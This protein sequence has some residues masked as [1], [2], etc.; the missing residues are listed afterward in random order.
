MSF[1]K[2]SSHQ[3]VQGILTPYMINTNTTKR[4]FDSVNEDS[5]SIG[6]FVDDP[7]AVPTPRPFSVVTETAKKQSKRGKR[8]VDDDDDEVEVKDA[9]TLAAL[10]A[11]AIARV[12]S[13]NARPS[14]RLNAVEFQA[15]LARNDEEQRNARQRR[16][17]NRQQSTD[18]PHQQEEKNNSSKV[19]VVSGGTTAFLTIQKNRFRVFKTPTNI[20]SSI[21]IG[22]NPQSVSI[23]SNLTLDLF[24]NTLTTN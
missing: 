23:D 17:E 15:R 3:L 14:S 11:A 20:Y 7:D 1:T 6:V 9:D 12:E 18:P 10:E 2:A 21:Q 5:R 22:G 13:R 24:Q 4:S 19:C 8:I 16:S